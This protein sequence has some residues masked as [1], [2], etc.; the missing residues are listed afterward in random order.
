MNTETT[1][2][3]RRNKMKFRAGGLLKSA[4]SGQM[5]MKE[6]EFHASL[7][8]HKFQFIFKLFMFFPGFIDMSKI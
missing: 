2:L 1:V 8:I 4:P 3:Q 6:M 5:V 7:L